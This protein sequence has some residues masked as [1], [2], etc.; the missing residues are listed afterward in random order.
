MKIHI[1]GASLVA[2]FSHQTVHAFSGP[3][4]GYENCRKT[5]ENSVDVPLINAPMITNNIRA[6]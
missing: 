3:L 4:T 6:R 1:S 2:F 5:A